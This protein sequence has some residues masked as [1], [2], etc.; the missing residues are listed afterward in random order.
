[1]L[2][3]AIRALK[4]FEEDPTDKDA[5]LLVFDMTRRFPQAMMLLA[6]KKYDI[7]MLNTP[8]YFTLRKANASVTVFNSEDYKEFVASFGPEE[9]DE[10][11]LDDTDGEEKPKRRKRAK[12]ESPE[13]KLQQTQPQLP[14]LDSLLQDEETEEIV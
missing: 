1:M 10:S 4:K 14:N 2:P 6:L 5:Q 8:D 7:L 9:G 13:Q 11:A 12:A 3:D